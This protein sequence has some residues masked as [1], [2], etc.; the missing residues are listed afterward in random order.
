MENRQPRR[1]PG[2]QEGNPRI[3]A[4]KAKSV[5]P[6]GNGAQPIKSHF[7]SPPPVVITDLELLRTFSKPKLFRASAPIIIDLPGL[8]RSEAE[9]LAARV[10]GYRNE[11]GCSLGAKCMAV[12]FGAM[13]AWLWISNGLFTMRFAWRLPLAFLF[14]LL[15][16]GLGKSIGIALARRRLH[17]ELNR[18][19]LNPPLPSAERSPCQVLGQN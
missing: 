7:H 1:A 14:A 10:N 12:G 9:A 13:V 15:C 4:T 8:S 17:S 18:L 16:A 11:C 5:N 2:E 19:D 3:S 6:H